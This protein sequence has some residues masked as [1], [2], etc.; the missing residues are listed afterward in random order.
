MMHREILWKHRKTSYGYNKAGRLA[1][2]CASNGIRVQYRYDRNDMQTEVLYGN[3]L[4]ISYTYDERSQLTELHREKH[5]VRYSYDPAGN[6]TEENYLT[7]D[8]ASTKKLHYAY[9]VYNRNGNYSAPRLGYIN[10]WSKQRKYNFCFIIALL[11]KVDNFS[12]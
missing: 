3:G 10:F 8:G 12:M 1:E 11:R 2:V 5:V 6:L 7:A 4:R 9:D